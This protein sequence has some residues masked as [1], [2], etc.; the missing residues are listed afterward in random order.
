VYFPPRKARAM[1]ENL[2]GSFDGIGVEYFSI[3]DTLLVTNVVKG[4]P[5]DKAGILRGDKL[6]WINDSLIAGVN[7][8]QQE[9]SD[10]VRGKRGSTVN[11]WVSRAGK[12]IESPIKI[13]RDQIIIS[14]IDVAYLIEPQT[15]YIRIKRFSERTAQEFEK[16]LKELRQGSF[17]K[18]I[19]DLRGNGGGYFYTALAVADNFFPADQL[20]VY[21]A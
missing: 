16:A 17:N 19:L 9:I 21:T 3:N 14:S 11:V 13:K 2:S 20:L 8:S 18:L 12:E 7:R 4:G 5:A 15:A 10:L 6:I 1:E